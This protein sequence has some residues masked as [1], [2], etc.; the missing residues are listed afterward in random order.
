MVG[1]DFESFDCFNPFPLKIHLFTDLF[2]SLINLRQSPYLEATESW[3]RSRGGRGG[4]K[5]SLAAL[6]SEQN[7]DC[8]EDDFVSLDADKKCSAYIFQAGKI[9]SLCMSP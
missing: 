2:H 9:M 6:E 1:G 4:D 7:F 3:G 5:V 8:Q